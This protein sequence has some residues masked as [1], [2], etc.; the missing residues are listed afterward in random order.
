MPRRLAARPTVSPSGLD[1]VPLSNSY[2]E[3]MLNSNIYD[4]FFQP[5]VT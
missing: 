3:A 4:S 2:I 5:I 1:I